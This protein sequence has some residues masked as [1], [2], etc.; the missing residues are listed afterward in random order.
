[1]RGTNQKGNYGDFLGLLETRFY[2]NGLNNILSLNEV[3][4]LFVITYN[5]KDK[6][7]VVHTKGEEN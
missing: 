3:Y 2:P 4:K 5:H 6:I 1:M 7:F